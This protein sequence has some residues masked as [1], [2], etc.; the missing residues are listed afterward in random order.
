M[1]GNSS[2]SAP[3]T[4]SDKQDP[5]SIP[6]SVLDYLQPNYWDQRFSSEDNYEWLKDYSHFE[7]LL[8]EHVKATHSVLEIGCGSSHLCEGLYRDG[9]TDITCTDLSKVAVEKLQKWV[10][11]MGYHGIKVVEADM[12]DLPFGDGCYDFVIEKGTMDLLFVDSGDPWDPHPATVSKVMAT[13]RGVH[14]VLKTDGIFV[15][16]SFGQPHFRR[17][18]FEA[19]E[20][21]WSLD[22]KTFGDGFHY[23][24]YVLKK[25]KRTSKSNG[26]KIVAPSICLLQ[27]ELE[28]EDYIFRTNFDENK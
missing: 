11:S 19:E 12:L 9:I 16:I 4:K 2:N 7:H 1:E 21:L 13:L 28:G 5:S 27:E 3:Q 25:G 18:F 8:R 23:F 24:F 6:S 14:R 20:F 22:W 10:E 17:P 26:I 15:S